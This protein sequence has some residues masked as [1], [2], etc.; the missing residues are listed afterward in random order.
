LHIAFKLPVVTNA[1][2]H[3]LFLYTNLRKSFEVKCFFL[4]KKLN[5]SVSKT[6]NFYLTANGASVSLVPKTL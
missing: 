3:R 2:S 6:Y 4:T 5:V 1:K